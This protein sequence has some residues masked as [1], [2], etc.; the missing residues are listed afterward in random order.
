MNYSRLILAVLACG[1]L[2][3]CGDDPVPQGPNA[4]R[5]DVTYHVDYTTDEV[6]WVQEDTV[7]A[8]DIDSSQASFWSC[9]FL[10][11]SEARMCYYDSNGVFTQDTTTYY[12]DLQNDALF[13]QHPEEVVPTAF[14]LLR[15]NRD[16]LILRYFYNT[17]GGSEE[18]IYHLIGH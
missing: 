8:S 3:A 16:S 4:S 15:W 11:H 9:R 1:A 5:Y 18:Y 7:I 13:L 2:W 12:V 6:G 10:N 14:E 17:P